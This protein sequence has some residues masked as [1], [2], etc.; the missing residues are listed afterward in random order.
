MYI[1]LSVIATI[2]TVLG[3]GGAF[4]AWMIKRITDTAKSNTNKDKAI[5]HLE[6][7]YKSLSKSIDSLTTTIQE[8]T[9]NINELMMSIVKLETEIVG[10]LKQNDKTEENIRDL[11][12]QINKL[13]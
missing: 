11:Y 4:I 10:I 7:N 1:S 3:L 12:S 9:K 6:T 13:K 5:E 8:F 2:C